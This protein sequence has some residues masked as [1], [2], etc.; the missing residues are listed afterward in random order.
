MNLW[1]TSFHI[2]LIYCLLFTISNDLLLLYCGL[3]FAKCQ[4]TALKL[5]TS[6]HDGRY[7]VSS[8][9]LVLMSLSIHPSLA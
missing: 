6:I 7:Y 2:L 9:S 3:S 4:M 8:I 1:I 5:A